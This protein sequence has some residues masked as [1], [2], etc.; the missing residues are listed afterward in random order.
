[1]KLTVWGAAKEVTGSCH[2]V[3][4]AGK[5]IVLDCG[6][7]QGGRDAHARNAAPLPFDPHGIDAV[8]L[9]HAHID[10]SGRLP[11]LVKQGYPGKIYAQRATR[12]LCRIMLQDS[13]FIQ[14]KG[15]EWENRK[16]A[17]KHLKPTAALYDQ[18]D[19]RRTMRHFRGVDF[20]KSFQPV[21]GVRVTLHPAGHIIG[22]SVIEIVDADGR[23]LVFSGDLGTDHA[24]L[25]AGPWKP[26]A[27]D[28]LVVE[29]TYGDRLHRSPE[30]T[31]REMGDILSSANADKGNILI[32]AFA[33]GRTQQILHAFKT[34]YADWGLH[35]WRI[36]LDSPLAIAAS[37]VHIKHQD[38]LRPEV[39]RAPDFLDMENVHVS[40]SA[41]QSMAINKISSGAIIVAGSGMCE[42]G[43]IR[44]HLKHNLWRKSCHVMIVGFQAGGTLGRRLVDGAS[45]VSLWGEA[46]KVG[47]K[48]HTIGGLSAHA[49]QN[50]LVNWVGA[51]T[52]NP[53]TVI[54]HGEPDSQAAL[55]AALEARGLFG[56]EAASLGDAYTVT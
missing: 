47:A 56:A 40:K 39:A 1:M 14:E 11:L 42:G 6:L 7:I 17:R 9:S 35:R 41:N 26:Q 54:V 13:A 53:R 21:P 52:G 29:S 25:L 23:R 2:L 33:V 22:A 16:R 19:V 43:R 34:H 24:P 44:H 55:A 32:P 46:V 3:E 8:I 45:R 31:W 49:D 38:L 28:L 20:S 48:V 5:R 30:D 18:D 4:V 15:A 36:F 10:H 50:D 12:D 51:A 27:C 37:D